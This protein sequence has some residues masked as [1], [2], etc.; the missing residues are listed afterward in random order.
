MLK[1]EE[2]FIL[3]TMIKQAYFSAQSQEDTEFIHSYFVNVIVVNRS[4]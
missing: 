3:K 4:A 1:L 2:H